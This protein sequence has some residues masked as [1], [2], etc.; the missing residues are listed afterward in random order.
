LFHVMT[1]HD[2]AVLRWKSYLDRDQAFAATGTDTPGGGS[3]PLSQMHPR[4]PQ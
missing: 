2:G 3:S 1:L 4:P